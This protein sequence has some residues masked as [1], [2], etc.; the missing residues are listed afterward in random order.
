MEWTAKIEGMKSASRFF[1]RA[2]AP[3][4][5]VSVIVDLSEGNFGQAAVNS[6]IIVAVPTAVM[7]GYPAVAGAIA[8]GG[9]V[10]GVVQVA[11][12]D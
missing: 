1:G 5:A 7:F 10:Y 11:T 9:A 4:A 12:G 8:A 3:V 2:G 6:A